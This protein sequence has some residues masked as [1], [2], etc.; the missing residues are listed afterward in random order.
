MALTVKIRADASQFKKTIAGVEVQASGLTGVMAKLGGVMGTA[1]FAG[2]LTAAAA[3]AVALGA[4]LSFIKDASSKAAGIESLTMQFETLLGS[5]KAAGERMAEIK[6]FAASTPFEV[7]NLSETSKLLQTLGGDMLATGEG[8]RMVGDAAA[9]AGQPIQEV[10]LHFGR[11]FNAI[12]SGTSAGESIGRLQELGLMTGKV[13]LEFED[14]AEAQK[15]GTKPAL[16]QVTAMTLLQGVFAK[17]SGAMQRLS[18]TTEGMKSNFADAVDNLKVNFGMG[19]NEGLK[20][21]LEAVNGFLP[22]L[23][24]RFSSV[25]T[26]IGRAIT[27]AVNGDYELFVKIGLVIGEAIKAGFMDVAGNLIVDS[28]RGYTGALGGATG[29]RGEAAAGIL[30]N[31]VL[32]PKASIGDRAAD[33]ATQLRPLIDDVKAERDKTN[34][35][36]IGGNTQQQ[37]QELKRVRVAVEEQLK[38]SRLTRQERVLLFSR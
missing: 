36:L 22:Q 2:A 26:L 5:S 35:E 14:L 30:G 15:K 1:G 34:P 18:T 4:G 38:G 32:G 21:A 3:G 7:A 28:I 10:G 19:F 25:G 33:I 37:M 31:A 12:T 11:I 20:S 6:K 9:I 8:L 27:N 23:E 13:K 16:D 29:A 24:S 17:T